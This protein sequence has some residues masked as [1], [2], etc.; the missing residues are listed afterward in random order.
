MFRSN[1]HIQN[2]FPLFSFLLLI[3]MTPGSVWA[4]SPVIN[5]FSVPGTVKEMGIRLVTVNASDPDGD[6]LTYS[7]S[8]ESDPT[9]KARFFDART[10]S[11]PKTISGVNK[12]LVVFGVGDPGAGPPGPTA[13]QGQKVRLRVEVSDGSNTVADSS[14]V[15]VSGFNQR[16][17]IELNTSYCQKLGTDP[18]GGDLVFT[19]SVYKCDVFYDLS[20][21][22]VTL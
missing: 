18:L 19:D 9:K 21:A 2:T 11:F 6:S 1:Q 8:F 16:P 20:E 3:V 13:I 7:W 12:T 4:G 10:V 22:P 17:V 5:S 14:L 15:T